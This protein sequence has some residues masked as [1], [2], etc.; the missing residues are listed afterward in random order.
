MTDISL[1]T[2]AP[3]LQRLVLQG[4]LTIYD[5]SD[6][7]TR[8][9]DGLQDGQVIELDLAQ[10]PE[11]DTSGVQLL[12]LLER[13]VQRLGGRLHITAVSGAVREVLDFCRLGARFGLAQ[14]GS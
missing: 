8:L 4:P 1:H 6:L 11:I 12:L 2:P 10:V 14:N 5:A 7:K 13:E 3:G 9:L